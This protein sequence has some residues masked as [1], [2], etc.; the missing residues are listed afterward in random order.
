MEESEIERLQDDLS[1][2][3][4]RLSDYYD[5]DSAGDWLAFPHP[6]LAN[7][8]PLRFI[9]RGQTRFVGAILDRLDAD[10]FI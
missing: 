2:V 8:S 3:L 1:R 7:Q 5:T 4:K 10:V 9:V 6:Q